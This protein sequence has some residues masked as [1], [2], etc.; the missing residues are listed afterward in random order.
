MHQAIQRKENSAV[1]MDSSLLEVQELESDVCTLNGEFVSYIAL[2]VV[3]FGDKQSYQVDIV[4][5]T[6]ELKERWNMEDTFGNEFYAMRRALH[7]ATHYGS[8]IRRTDVNY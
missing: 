3:N 6:A 1:F 8:E 5:I 7:L 2:Q 4:T